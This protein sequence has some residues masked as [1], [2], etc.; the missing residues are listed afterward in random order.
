WAS[1]GQKPALRVIDHLNWNAMS[2]EGSEF[3]DATKLSVDGGPTVELIL[4]NSSPR[5]KLVIIRAL[6]TVMDGRGVQHFLAD[7]F[8]SLRNETPL[9][10]NADFT[11]ED[12]TRLVKPSLDRWPAER[13]V[14]PRRLTGPP[15]G[16]DGD[17]VWCRVHLHLP[18][19][20]LLHRFE[21]ASLVFD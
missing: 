11:Y 17:D 10:T 21:L 12:L 3:L 13:R 1:D 4:V 8:R 20:N 19:R 2:Q 18:W 7:V 9:G 16:P 5:G 14:R 15:L 6:H